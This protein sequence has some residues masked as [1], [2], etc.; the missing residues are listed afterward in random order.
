MPVSSA[1]SVPTAFVFG[2]L[3][4]FSPCV[5]PLVPAY[6]SYM[7]GVSVEELMESRGSEALKRT[8]AKSVLFVLGF[9][10]VFVAMGATATSVGQLLAAKMDILMKIGGVVIVI[11][12]MHMTGVFRIKALYAEKRFH[13]R[14]RNVGFVGAFLIGVTFA[15]GWTPCVGPVLAG[16]LTL[17]VN[18][19]TV[20]RGVGLLAVYS[21]GLGIPFIITGFAA[22]TALAALAKFKSR[23][24]KIE[25]ASGIL[26]VIVGILVFTGSLQDLSSL[27]SGG[28]P[29]AH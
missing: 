21:L 13:M 27:L 23:L 19:E 20:L 5:L 11:L 8:G 9:S 12:G 3:S 22:G 14:L 24:R 10:A 18:S 29:Q 17:A 26:V 16:I 15:F 1:V 7:S 4:F 25:I 28:F 2:L 6:L